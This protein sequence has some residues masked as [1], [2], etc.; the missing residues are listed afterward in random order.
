[1]SKPKSENTADG[2][3]EITDLDLTELT[4]VSMHDSAALP[5]SAASYKS[6][7]TCYV[8]PT[9]PLNK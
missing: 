3:L 4:V 2:N 1:V 9:R 7:S 6:S 8:A 5:E